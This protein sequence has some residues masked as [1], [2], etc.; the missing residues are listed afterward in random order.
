MAV[1]YIIIGERLHV[2]RKKAKITQQELAEK[3]N[4]SVAYVSRVER[5][6]SHINLKR[7]TEFCSIFG[8]S[9]G[10]ILNGV[11]YNGDN[12][13][14]SEF[15]EILNKCSPQKQKLIYKLSKLIAEDDE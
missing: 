4:I 14:S 2:A 5:G 15:T 6:S 11:S 3:L 7:L 13:L 9:E 8:V 1:D 12:Y 10:D